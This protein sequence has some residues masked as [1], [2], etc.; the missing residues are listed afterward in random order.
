LPNSFKNALD[1]IEEEV[2]MLEAEVAFNK[3]ESK[4]LKSE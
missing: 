2:K 4:I 1:E 3:K